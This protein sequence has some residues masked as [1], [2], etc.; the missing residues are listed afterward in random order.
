MQVYKRSKNMNFFFQVTKVQKMI[1]KFFVTLKSL[2]KYEL[3]FF[4]FKEAQEKW[5]QFL[6][7][8]EVLNNS[9]H[10]FCKSQKLK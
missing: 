4:K 9:I 7:S 2:K 3:N 1:I 8:L 10:I 5:I 6:P